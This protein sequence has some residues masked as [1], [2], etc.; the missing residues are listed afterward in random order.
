MDLYPPAASGVGTFVAVV[1]GVGE[2]AFD[3]EQQRHWQQRRLR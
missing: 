3:G 1:G 2:A